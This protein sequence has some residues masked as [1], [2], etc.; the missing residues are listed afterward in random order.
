MLRAAKLVMQRGVQTAETSHQAF[1][2]KCEAKTSE[3]RLAAGDARP[4]S[5]LA[6]HVTGKKSISPRKCIDILRLN[7][8]SD[9][10]VCTPSL[11]VPRL[12]CCALRS[13]GQIGE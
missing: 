4:E 5:S 7:G 8:C 13:A 10:V 2:S 12:M 1:L 9:V 11:R 6:D 3:T